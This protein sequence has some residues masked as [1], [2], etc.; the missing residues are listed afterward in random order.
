MAESLHLKMLHPELMSEISPDLQAEATSPAIGIPKR[1]MGSHLTPEAALTGGPGGGGG[2]EVRT[3]EI[4]YNSMEYEASPERG[5]DITEELVEWEALRAGG[6]YVEVDWGRLSELCQDK[7]AHTD[8]IRLQAMHFTPEE[9][10]FNDEVDDIDDDAPAEAPKDAKRPKP[11]NID[12]A[13]LNTLSAPASAMAE[14][15]EGRL[16]YPRGVDNE[17]FNTDIETLFEQAKEVGL[18]EGMDVI[19]R[20]IYHGEIK[21]AIA[22]KLSPDE[23]MPRITQ[24]VQFVEA[25]IAGVIRTLG[26]NNPD[27]ARLAGVEKLYGSM[28]LDRFNLALLYHDFEGVTQ[29][30]FL[31]YEFQLREEGAEPIK[32]KFWHLEHGIYIYVDAKT[33]EEYQIAAESYLARL[34]SISTSPGELLGEAKQFVQA[35]EKSEGFD[36]VNERHP[37]FIT[38]LVFQI[39]ARIG[40]F[41]ADHSDELYHVDELKQYLDYINKDGKGPDRWLSLMELFDG[42]VAAALWALDRDPTWEILFSLHGSRGDIARNFDAQRNRGEDGD[43]EQGIYAEALELLIQRMMGV[44]ITNKKNVK[45]ISKFQ[46]DKKF[47]G[48]FDGLY[49]YGKVPEGRENGDA[50]IRS[51]Q[52]IQEALVKRGLSLDDLT[53]NIHDMPEGRKSAL[54]AA[55]TRFLETAKAARWRES[56]K[57]GKARLGR[58]QMAI[59]PATKGGEGLQLEDLSESDQKFYKEA[60]ERAA[61]AVEIA[62]QIMGATGEK[63]K[64]GGGVFS[65][66]RREGDKKFEDFVPIHFAEKFVQFAETMTKIKFRDDSEAWGGEAWKTWDTPIANRIR[67]ENTR[68]QTEE[69]ARLTEENKRIAKGNEKITEENN[70]LAAE[71][72]KLKPLKPLREIR[73]IDPLRNFKAQYRTAKVAQAREKAI[74]EFAGI[75]ETADGSRVNGKGFESKLYEWDDNGE[76][77]GEMMLNMPR[78]DENEELVKG[79]DGQVLVDKVAVTFYMATHH[80]FGDWTPHTYWGYQDEHR[81]M[82]LNPTTFAQAIMIRDGKLRWEDADPIAVQ[83]LILDPT[84]KRVRAF[85]HDSKEN[86]E[87]E[88]KLAMAAVEDSYQGH[89]RLSR[90]LHRAFWPKLGD[91]TRDIHIYNGMQ[92]YGGVLKVEGASRARMAENPERFMR[93]GRRLLPDLHN[94]MTALSEGWGLGVWG[95]TG[96]IRAM[97]T[98]IY[99]LGGTFA[100]DKYSAQVEVSFKIYNSLVGT[101][102]KEDGFKEGLLLKLTNESDTNLQE[103]WHKLPDLARDGKWT[104][105]GQQQDFC[106]AVRKA[107]G[108]LEA[109]ERLLTVWESDIRNASGALSME[110]VDVLRDNAELDPEIDRAF[111]ALPDITGKDLTRADYELFV[112]EAERIANWGEIGFDENYNEDDLDRGSTSFFTGSGRHSARI[113]HDTFFALMLDDLMRGGRELYEGEKDI[114]EHLYDKIVVYDPTAEG[115]IRVTNMTIIDW[116]FTKTVPT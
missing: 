89:H 16:A 114:L 64:R 28:A 10:E 2:T 51:W 1:L 63:A 97:G 95:A 94:P 102:T 76:Q 21:A 80:P 36:E 33:P 7:R 66:Q 62:F 50:N 115:G 100:L 45:H 98:P 77:I 110:N 37:G 8:A 81:A 54:T 24:R 53:Q 59:R 83:L 99:R 69:N 14:I 87:R 113:F 65:V 84:L 70:K 44:E 72:K 41:G 39:E 112:K 26:R 58:I 61:K 9:P 19:L 88:G 93:R 71:G 82:L 6:K 4:D 67:S 91:P 48:M 116:L 11:E 103:W 27:I 15:H 85:S 55:Q 96:A 43:K 60:H 49:R 104:D 31:E 22:S 25:S 23:V 79:P 17:K 78:E 107:F 74:D 46:S 5:M 86:V 30:D 3:R 101:T 47:T 106:V 12:V 90:E 109:Y 73:P 29:G 108:R 18:L 13:K 38:K 111:S 105:P 20:D 92:D 32:K 35:I 68:K 42:N 40:V 75:A 57:L 56:L 52:L 34:E